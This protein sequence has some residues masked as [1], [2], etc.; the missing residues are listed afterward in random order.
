MLSVQ[1]ATA[2]MCGF[3]RN[4][5]LLGSERSLPQENPAWALNLYITFVFVLIILCP[6]YWIRSCNVTIIIISQRSAVQ[7][8][9]V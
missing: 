7:T 8:V 4:H 9:G 2:E 1:S 3:S 6:I 5:P